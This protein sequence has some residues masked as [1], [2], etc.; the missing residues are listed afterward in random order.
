MKQQKDKKETIIWRGWIFPEDWKKELMLLK[1][2][3]GIGKKNL[4]EVVVFLGKK[5]KVFTAEEFL[6]ILG[7]L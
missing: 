5:K 4:E 2:R 1:G 7:F 3:K 6:V